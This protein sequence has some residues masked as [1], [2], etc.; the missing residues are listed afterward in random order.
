[1]RIC[2]VIDMAHRAFRLSCDGR[3]MNIRTD[4]GEPCLVENRKVE[5][6]AQPKRDELV[7]FGTALLFIVGIMLF[8]IVRTDKGIDGTLLVAAAMIGGYMAM[9]ITANDVANNV[10]PAVGSNA[11]TLT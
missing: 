7:R 8:D 5:N 4:R 9:N 3:F 2:A 6:A 1:M 10:G 11:I